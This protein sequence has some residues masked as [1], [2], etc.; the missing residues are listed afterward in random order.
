MKPAATLVMLLF[1]ATAMAQVRGVPASVTSTSPGN[2][3]PGVR[4]SVS[5]QSTRSYN[6]GVPAS[7]TSLGPQ[8]WQG[9]SHG[10]GTHSGWQHGTSQFGNP[11]ALPPTTF[12]CFGGGIICAPTTFPPNN[13]YTGRHHHDRYGYGYSGYG[14]G[15]GYG[16]DAPYYYVDPSA[17]SSYSTDSSYMGMG[18]GYEYLQPSANVTV[19]PDPPAPTI[20]E[21]RP[22]TRPYARDEARYDDSYG[23][24]AADAVAKPATRSSNLGVGEQDATTL[25]FADGHKM[26]VHNYAIVGSNLFNFDGTGPFKVK[27]SELNLGATE[28]LNEDNGVEFK[29]PK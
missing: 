14:Y 28:K 25:V 12:S 7:V 8:G 20:Y 27:L 11:P 29:L 16:R 5:S 15:Y 3:N 9:G 6:P 21:R 23:G 24:P 4:A 17:Y 13:T 22:S 1:A 2:P 18:A 19:E 10:N 26:D